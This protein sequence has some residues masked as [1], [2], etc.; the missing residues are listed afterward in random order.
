MTGFWIML[1]GAVNLNEI[2]DNWPK[3]RCQPHIIPFASFFGHDTTENFNFCM[4]GILV[5]SVG[6]LFAPVVQIL[7]TF[8]ETLSTLMMMANSMRLQMATMTGGINTVFQNFTDRFMQLTSAV[9]N[10]AMRMRLLMQRLYSTFFAMLYL[11]MSAMRAL[12]NFG[13][14][15]LF[16]FLDTF[17]FPPETLIN[18]QG[19]GSIMIK[20]V[21]IGDILASTGAKVTSTFSF[22]AD[23]QPMVELDGG[24][25]VSTNHYLAAE[26]SFIRADQHPDAKPIMPWLGGKERPLICLNTSD[27]RIPI[28][29]YSFLDY[30]ET[31]AAEKET[32]QMVDSQVNIGSA[33]S[34]DAYD[35]SYDTV[36]GEEVEIRMKDGSLKQSGELKLDDMLSLGK[37]I[38]VI[39]KKVTSYCLTKTNERVTPGTLIWSEDDEK[40]IRAGQLYEIIEC[41]P[42]IFYGAI[43]TPS[44]II[45]TCKGLKMRDYLEIHSPDTERHYAAAIAVEAEIAGTIAGIKL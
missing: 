14:T 16:K 40:W 3:Y 15:F 34:L 5:A 25:Q 10:T 12:Q 22:I 21:C 7:A 27:H 24:I 42:T 26:N 28:G 41:V 1:S 2:T 38:A 17:C 19:K 20:D 6:P 44:A 43:V 39:Q 8:L 33:P 18:I 9:Q 30:D 11:S 31:E 23:G 13:D 36:F 45:Q 37:V 32:M 29:G 4:K 35:F